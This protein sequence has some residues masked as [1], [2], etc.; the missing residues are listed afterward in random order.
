MKTCC[1]DELPHQL[2]LRN[3]YAQRIAWRLGLSPKPARR[4][5]AEDIPPNLCQRVVAAERRLALAQMR[6]FIDALERGDEVLFLTVCRPEW[7]CDAGKL[8]ASMIQ[9]VRNWMSRRARNLSRHGRQRMLGFVDIAWN[10]RTAVNQTSHWSVHAHVLVVIEGCRQA[11]RR[12]CRSAF[13]CIGECE[14]VNKPIVIKRLASD[15]DVLRVCQY[16][17]R[18]LLLEHHQRRRSYLDRNKI[19]Q[20]R[21][22]KL[23]VSQAVELASVVHQVGPK[24]FWILSGLRRKFGTIEKHG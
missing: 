17:S 3:R 19:A 5:G 24:G 9:E 20:T 10:D 1:F 18:A 7:T 11:S 16:N 13:R 15:L 2:T 21:D 6:L 12:L 4:S 22:T 23:T 8:D 14:R